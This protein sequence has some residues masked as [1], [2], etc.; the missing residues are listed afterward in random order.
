MNVRVGRHS[1]I[2]SNSVVKINVPDYSVADGNPAS[3]IMTYD[4]ADK[5][6]KPCREA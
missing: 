1:V 4:Q 5:R 3:V 2:G 6:W